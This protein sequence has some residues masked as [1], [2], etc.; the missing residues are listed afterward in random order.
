MRNIKTEIINTTKQVGDL[1]DWLILRHSP[2]EPYEPTMYIDLD[3]VNLCREGSL[4][5]LT[6][7]IDTGIPTKRVCLIDVYSLG[8]QAF[9]TT[10]IKGKTLKDI[11]QDEKIP[12]VFFDVRNDSDALFAHF[13]VALQGVEDV[14]LMESA[15]RTTTSSRKYLNGLAKC[16]EKSVL[17]GSDLRSWKL[18]KEKV[19]QSFKAESGGSYKVFEQRP[20]PTEIISYCVGDVQYLP[21]LWRR[22][23]SNTNRW[24]DLVNKETKKRVEASQKPEYQPHGPGRTLAPWSEDQNRTLDKWSGVPPSRDDFDEDDGWIDNDWVD[25][26]WIDDGPTSCRDIIDDCDYYLYYSD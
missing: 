18:V 1:V 14:Q 15:T 2:P 13:G 6:L 24:R 7:L 25:D 3:G 8:S 10:G 17:H 11:L 12:K 26:D 22:F 19:G 16:I 23:R 4:S 20:I 9:N 5:I 21:Q